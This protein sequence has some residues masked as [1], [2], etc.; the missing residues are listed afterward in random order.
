MPRPM[1]RDGEE[2]QEGDA[3]VK[4]DAAAGDEDGT[5]TSAP[6]PSALLQQQQS[7][8]RSPRLSLSVV[9]FGASG[10]LAH[11]KVMPS[12]FALWA[13]RKLPSDTRFF[14]AARSDQTDLQWRESL[15]SA[16][17][18]GDGKAE[19]QV[20]AFLERCFYSKLADYSLDAD[21]VDALGRRMDL[22]EERSSASTLGR[23]FY[24]AVPVRII[25]EMAC[26]V[27]TQYTLQQQCS[28]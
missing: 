2:L 19:Q 5:P 21:G 22:E 1:P 13:S 9:V 17:S 16:L 6:T 28:C 27:N 20:A 3:A 25:E 7:P 4:K 12:L 10:D 15:R 26:C 23:L 11:K 14:G 18:G 8:I 24:L